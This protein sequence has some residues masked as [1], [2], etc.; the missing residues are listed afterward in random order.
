MLTDEQFTALLNRLSAATTADAAA[1]PV[2]PQHGARGGGRPTLIAKHMR[3]QTFDGSAAA[4]GDWAFGLKRAIRSQSRDIFQILEEIEKRTELDEDQLAL[5]LV[6][7]EVERLSGEVYDILCQSVSGEAMAIVRSVEDYRGFTAW[8]KLHLKYN[9]RTKARL[10]RLM[11]EVAGPGP[12]KDVKDVPAAIQKWEGKLKVLQRE[13]NEKLSDHMRIAI[14]TSMM[15]TVIQDYIYQNISET[16]LFI[17]MVEKVK[18]WVG[19]RV[20]MMTGPSPMDVGEVADWDENEYDENGDVGAVGAYTECHRCGGFGHMQ[21]EC[22]T[23]AAKGKGKG[24]PSHYHGQQPYESGGQKG[25][26]GKG[27][28]KGWSGDG[29]GY[30]GKGT[31]GTGKGYQGTCWKCGLVGHKALECTV[32][33]ANLVV[34][35]YH[36]DEV[37]VGGVWM[38]G[39]VDAKV[40]HQTKRGKCQV[41]NSFQILEES[42]V[43]VGLTNEIFEESSVDVGLTNEIF[44]EA[45]RDDDC[46]DEVF[47]GTV[48]GEAKKLSRL[49]SMKFNVASVKKPL[50]SAV[51]V[52]EAGN[53]ISMGPR[54]GDNFIENLVTGE[55][56]AIRVDRGT[57]VFDVEFANGEDGTITLDSGAGVNVWPQEM[58]PELPL[59]AKEPGLRMTAANGTSIANL[60]TKLVQF[61][62]V[63]P[64]FTGRA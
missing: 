21:R 5:D 41:R 28:A 50:A 59:M 12:V 63:A 53:R 27:S 15:P 34:N 61:R 56:L 23:V 57:Y 32:A 55:K 40:K 35:E 26:K 3:L 7:V 31:K 60:G 43:E 6:D 58:L 22:P 25:Y 14:L 16:T 4:W 20:A 49:S 36:E 42:S 48:V 39:H 13:F 29:K 24:K 19:N 2:G 38:I 8:Q 17:D 62:G 51:K 9:P 33:R 11:G 46:D 30:K 64:G 47:V 37:D 54:P 18:S 45:D 1:T 10:I 52:V 44:E